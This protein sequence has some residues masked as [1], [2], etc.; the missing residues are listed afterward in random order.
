MWWSQEAGQLI[1]I[2]LF[3]D[4]MN[5]ELIVQ[6]IRPGEQTEDRRLGG[7]LGVIIQLPLGLTLDVFSKDTSFYYLH[8]GAHQK[9]KQ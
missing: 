2:D 9:Q 3:N 1:C 7:G 4:V 5:R 8:Q 6:C